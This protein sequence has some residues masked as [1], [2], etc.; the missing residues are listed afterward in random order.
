M[1]DTETQRLRLAE[2]LAVLTRGLE[3]LGVRNSEVM[4]DWV[5]VAEGTE[6]TESDENVLADKYEDLTT[7]DA[8]VADLETRF[9]NVTR[10]LEKIA[11]GTY[12]TC[13]VGGEPIEA[14]RL[15]ANPAARTCKLHIEDEGTLSN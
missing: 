3:S 10:A 8:I 7:R 14:D 1:N 4:S 9:N 5:P 12:G 2:E 15:N 11:A 13:E 6:V